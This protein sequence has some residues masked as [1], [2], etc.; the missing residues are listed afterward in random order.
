MQCW[1]T[2]LLDLSLSSH[3]NI[4]ELATQRTICRSSTDRTTPQTYL[5]SS[6]YSLSHASMP[7]N[8]YNIIYLVDSKSMID[9]QQNERLNSFPR[10]E[11]RDAQMCHLLY[12][13]RPETRLDY[14]IQVHVIWGCSF[15]PTTNRRLCHIC[16]IWGKHVFCLGDWIRGFILW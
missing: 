15:Y 12:K 16:M 9:Q 4:A 3:L 10:L 11:A 14:R 13:V 7:N 2:L 1:T 6:Q 5:Q 8:P